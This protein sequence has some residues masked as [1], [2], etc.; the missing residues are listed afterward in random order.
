MTV[1]ASRS[2]DFQVDF[3]VCRI[4]GFPVGRSRS[5][6]LEMR[7]W[8]AGQPCDATRKNACATYSGRFWPWFAALWLGLTVLS[9]RA[10]EAPNQREQKPLR[11]EQP[12]YLTGSIYSPVDRTQLLF[13]FTRKATRSGSRLNVVRDFT[14]P[15]GRL[16]ARERVVYDGDWL[17]IYE[18]DEVQT[19]S[20]GS[21]VLRRES[22]DPAEGTIEFEF[23]KSGGGNPGVRREKLAP[24]T[25]INDMVAPFLVSHWPALLRGEKPKCHFIVVPR[26]ETIGFMFSK[27]LESQW[28]GQSV[29][30][31]KMEPSSVLLRSLVAPVLFTI[32]KKPPHR[33]L[34]YTGRTIPKLHEG[35]SWKDLD[36]VTVFDW[37]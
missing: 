37:K 11:Y 35:R 23:M 7:R 15:D 27:V 28:Q 3:Q 17:M 22:G 29:I 12:V 31:I 9:T 24:D 19:G 13:H 8:R 32:Q 5:G 14:Y 36:A 2:A 16:A 34:E 25:L 21:A 30:V 4:A 20:K 18:L 6:R 1:R 26:K 10:A 33:I